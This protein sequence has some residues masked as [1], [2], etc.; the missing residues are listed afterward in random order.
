MTGNG[1]SLSFNSQT[2]N[3]FTSILSFVRV[4]HFVNQ[5]MDVF[6]SGKER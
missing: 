1:H 5:N 6:L 3:I 4:V 2:I